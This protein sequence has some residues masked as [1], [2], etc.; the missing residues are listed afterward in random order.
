MA[1]QYVRNK[2]DKEALWNRRDSHQKQGYGINASVHGENLTIARWGP[3]TRYGQI[4]WRIAALAAFVGTAVLAVILSR[5]PVRS[6]ANL[7]VGCAQVTA[8]A[9][10][11]TLPRQDRPVFVPVRIPVCSKKGHSSL[12]VQ[13]IQARPGVPGHPMVP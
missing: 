1:P 3:M 9:L 4:G 11:V 6:A 10:R 12:S 7:P 5:A 13:A 2:C 8:G